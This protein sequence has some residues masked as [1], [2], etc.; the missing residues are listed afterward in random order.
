MP[1]FDTIAIVDWSAAAHPGPRAPRANNIFIAVAGGSRAAPPAYHRTRHSAM[2]AL[3]ALADAEIAAGRRLLV[4]VDFP[5]GYPV[6]TARRI[7]GAAHAGALHARLADLVEDGADNASNRFALAASLNGLFAGEGPFWGCPAGAAHP[8]LGPRKP[9]R[10]AS[11]PPELRAADVAMRGAQPVW[12]LFTTGSVGSQALLGIAAIAR[13]AARLGDDCALWPFDG[14]F[15]APEAAVVVAEIYP[16]LIDGAIRAAQ[17]AGEIL[18]A[19]QVRVLAHAFARLDRGDALAPL[20]APPAGVASEALDIAA[21]EEGWCLGVERAMPAGIPC[22]AARR[23]AAPRLTAAAEQNAAEQDA[24]GQDAAGQDA[25]EQGAAEQDAAEQGA[26]G[27]DAA[28]QGAAGQDAAGQDAAGQDAAEA[29]ADTPEPAAAGTLPT[30]PGPMPSPATVALIGINE[31]GVAGLSP[32][33]RAALMGADVILGGDRHADLG[34]P[35]MRLPWP[36]DLRATIALIAEQAG[37]RVA[38]LAHG[39]PLWFSVGA[40]IARALGPDAVAVHPN[41]SSFQL[42][43]ARLVWSMADVETLSC[44][45]GAPERILPYLAPRARLLI[46]STGAGTPARIAD[47]LTER[48]WGAA[49]LT[50]LAA[51]GGPHEVRIDAEAR[52]FPATDLAFTL[53]AVDCGHGAGA[54]LRPGGS[55]WPG[56]AQGL[57]QDVRAAISTDLAPFRGAVLAALGQ[58]AAAVAA[59]WARA[60][61]DA[62]AAATPPDACRDACHDG[63]PEDDADTGPQD[64]PAAMAAALAEAPAVRILADPL[65]EGACDAALL[66]PGA[67]ARLDA[68]L[69][70][71][72]RPGRLVA[73]APEGGGDAAA[74]LAGHR[75]HGGRLRRIGGAEMTANGWQD[76][77]PILV[78][79]LARG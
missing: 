76:F 5:L 42:A 29:G 32:A 59:D 71:L 36:G 4:G 21:R 18:D 10:D 64:G 46:L 51:L 75:A 26:A 13:F 14:G 23:A 11:H 57:S 73:W 6:G 43:A 72:R 60:A 3:N 47:L 40:R 9:P 58:G 53:L 22:A 39:D 30:M 19:A 50:L 49:R 67:L 79:S 52:A 66:G 65:A 41:L 48:G 70:A 15:V 7:A 56:A 63:A 31:D 12:K 37:R 17:G 45:R 44:H 74:I 28:G 27:Q 2:A 38:V 68:A 78:W 54:R 62:R 35:G 24:A 1:L 55:A 61:R 25:A 33:A 69:A 20:F 16:S 8:G 34:A 77:A